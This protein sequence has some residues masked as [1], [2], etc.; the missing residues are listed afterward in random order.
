MSCNWNEQNFKPSTN[1]R[2]SL[3]PAAA[4]VP[5]PSKRMRGSDT[6][7]QVVYVCV[8]ACVCV[9][10]CVTNEA[11]ANIDIVVHER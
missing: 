8:C 7:F 3:V 10:V 9:C 6:R 4:V 2:A 5:A 1:W 11:P